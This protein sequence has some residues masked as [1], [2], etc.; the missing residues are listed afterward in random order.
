MWV[1]LTIQA[2]LPLTRQVI[3][4]DGEGVRDACTRGRS[5]AR[6]SK[7]ICASTWGRDTTTDV[8]G[9][10]AVSLKQG[11]RKPRPGSSR[12]ISTHINQP[13]VRC[14]QLSNWKLEPIRGALRATWNVRGRSKLGKALPARKD[15]CGG[16]ASSGSNRQNH[17]TKMRP[18][19]SKMHQYGSVE[20]DACE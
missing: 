8:L 17:A 12:S 4:F 20:A 16:S 1:G 3:T 6:E 15:G 10:G 18:R 5:R 11:S 7:L 13:F 19:F 14:R 9:E 2:P